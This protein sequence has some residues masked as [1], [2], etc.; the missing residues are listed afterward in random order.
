MPRLTAT[1]CALAGL[2]LTYHCHAA[3]DAAAEQSL[4]D[5]SL[6]ELSN[7]T[8]HSVSRQDTRL[9]D[10]P[11]AVYLI[12]GEDIRH[13]GATTLPEALRLAPNLQVAQV[14]GQGY[15]ITARGFSSRFE[16]KLLVM[17]D[18]RSIYSP[19]FSGVFWD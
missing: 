16:N 5:F 18:G 8:V 3:T 7:I 14:G 12:T 13:A 1:V 2:L 9:A 6:E 15:A 10:A 4:A 11:A 17:I 19:L